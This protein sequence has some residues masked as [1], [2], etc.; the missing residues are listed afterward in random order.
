AGLEGHVPVSGGPES[1]GRYGQPFRRGE[2]S[3][4]AEN[5]LRAG[6]VEVGEIVVDRLEIDSTRMLLGLED[7]LDL[8]SKR[9]AGSVPGVIQ[10][11]DS[12]PVARQEQ[13]RAARVPDREGKHTAQV[14]HAVFAEGVVGVEDRFGVARRA[15]PISPGCEL[16]AKRTEVVDLAVEYDG[17]GPVLAQHRLASGLQINDLQTPVPQPDRPGDVT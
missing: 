15:E 10:R 2:L 14:S 17:E 9:K 6:N 5:R 11:L 1:P 13:L 12:Q 4:V 7:G 3:N 8:R 16:I